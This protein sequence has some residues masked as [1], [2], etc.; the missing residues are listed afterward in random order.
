MQLQKHFKDAIMKNIRILPL[1]ILI[2]FLYACDK[3]SQDIPPINDDDLPSNLLVGNIYYALSDDP[4]I[5]DLIDV[6]SLNGANNYS[7]VNH[8]SLGKIAFAGQT[9]LSYSPDT[10]KTYDEDQFSIKGT[11]NAA[12]SLTDTIVI[13]MVNSVAELPCNAG[14]MADEYTISVNKPLLMNVLANDKFCNVN[15]DSLSLSLSVKPK[16]GKAELKNNQFLYTPNTGVKGTDTFIYKVCSSGKNGKC[17]YGAVKVNIVQDA[18][19]CKTIIVA[20]G[21]L[22]TKLAGVT[23][24]TMDVLKNDKLCDAYK[25][26]KLSILTVPKFG[27]AVVTADNKIKYSAGLNL[28]LF[29]TYEYQLCDNQDKNCLKG[30][31]LLTV[32]TPPPCKTTIYADEVG[33]SLAK[34][35]TS[36]EIEIPVLANDKVCEVINGIQANTLPK[37]GTIRIDGKKLYYKPKAGVTGTDTFKYQ[38]LT[39]TLTAKYEG[40]VSVKVA[41]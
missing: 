32:Y 26:S 35:P 34:L 33:L 5:L 25:L 24:V 38:V 8:P 39:A 36:G 23:D 6:S 3:I 40:N 41:K 22:W 19:I 30:Y 12:K 27:K 11:W 20:D 10:T 7:I 1:L 9:L 15:I 21:F 16:L 28:G 17:R 37:N 2:G 14:A 4:V 13:K 18:S 29:D 31:V